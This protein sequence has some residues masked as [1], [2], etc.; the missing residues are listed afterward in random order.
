METKEPRTD[1]RPVRGSRAEAGNL[2]VG[3]TISII[4]TDISF[5]LLP[6]HFSRYDVSFLHSS[7]ETLLLIA[8]SRFVGGPDMISYKQQQ[9]A[10]KDFDG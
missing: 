3:N 5:V 4:F 9:T 6:N 2:P 10:S 8:S 1:Q 7:A